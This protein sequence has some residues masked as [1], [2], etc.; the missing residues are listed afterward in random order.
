MFLIAMSVHPFLLK[1]LRQTSICLAVTL[2]VAH[3]SNAPAETAAPVAAVAAATAEPSSSAQA[4]FSRTKD[5]IV[6]VRVLLSS[7]NE[8]SSLGSGFLVR[9]DGQQGAWVVTNYHV[10]SA[11]AI[12]PQRYRMELRGTN[13]RVVEAELVAIDVIHDL[14]VL[15]TKP[16]AQTPASSWPVLTLSEQSLAQGSPVFSLGNPLE[17]GFLI[18]EGIYNGSVETRLYEQMLFSGSINSGMSGGPAI[19][20]RGH[21]V[22]VNVATRRDG[23]QLSFLVPVQY[24]KNLLDRSWASAPRTEWRSQIAQQLLEH[25]QFVTQKMLAQQEPQAA[26]D[27]NTQTAGFSAQSLADRS[28]PTLHGTLTRCWAQGRDGERL[29]FSRDRLNCS[30][31]EDVFVRNSLY[32]GTLE[33]EHDL[34]RNDKLTTP[35]FL[36]LGVGM[37]FVRNGQTGELTPNRCTDA[38]IKGGERVYR[39]A[40]CVRAYRKFPGLYDYTVRATQVDDARERLSS[41][42]TLRG[43]SFDNAQKLGQLFLERLQ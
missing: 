25:Q 16:V 1:A 40:I 18:S 9:D 30:L 22:G 15:R 42:L 24:A 39:A 27:Q 31:R 7:A 12:H 20:Q 17:L 35:Q 11:L 43:F 6:Q 4:L 10:I 41:Q 34:L 21:V 32:T 13:Q 26:E 37:G 29:R 28:V 14:A 8:Q 23:Q 5:G 33:L 38:Y 19:D 36:E 3:A 2:G